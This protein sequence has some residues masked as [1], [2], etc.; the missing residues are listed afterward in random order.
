MKYQLVHYTDMHV[1][2]HVEL[3]CRAVAHAWYHMN[4]AAYLALI[5][6]SIT[7][8]YRVLTNN[9]AVIF[10]LCRISHVGCWAK[11]QYGF[12]NSPLRLVGFLTSGDG[13][14]HTSSVVVVVKI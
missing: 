9:Y 8:W 6:S 4:V 11:W 1:H 14:G 13:D 3:T 2:V 7:L 5:I 10:C 12:P